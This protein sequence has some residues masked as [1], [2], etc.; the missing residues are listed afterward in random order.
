MFRCQKSSRKGMILQFSEG[1]D[2]KHN[3]L[4]QDFIWCLVQYLSFFRFFSTERVVC[5]EILLPLHSQMPRWRNGRRAR[6]RCEC[7]ETCRFESYSG[8]K[9]L[10]FFSAS[11]FCTRNRTRSTGG[12]SAELS[13][14][15]FVVGDCCAIYGIVNCR[16]WK[17]VFS[18]QFP[19]PPIF[20]C[21]Y[22]P[23]LA[24]LSSAAVG[25][26]LCGWRPLIFLRLII[27]LKSK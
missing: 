19:T 3:Q 20:D 9:T 12:D 13:A 2:C 18:R 8:H 25:R 26:F 17:Q 4:W 10:R 21:A 5:S 15:S 14:R 1:F 24:L 6:F 16:R 7:W 23:P 22:P 11:F 27:P